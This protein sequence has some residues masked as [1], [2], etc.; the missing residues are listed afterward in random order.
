ME[1]WARA[2][3]RYSFFQK[4]FVTDYDPTIEDSY[5][6][7]LRW[8]VDIACLMKVE[9]QE[10][11]RKKERGKEK[12]EEKKKMKKKE[13]EEEKKKKKVE[14]KKQEVVEKE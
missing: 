7:T 4:L 11:V 2:V 14:D 10:E 12:K 1:A 3:S 5:L 6:H 9:E 8:M 13:E